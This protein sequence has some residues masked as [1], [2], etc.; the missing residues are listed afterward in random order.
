MLQSVYNI[1]TLQHR[2][3]IGASDVV[4]ALHNSKY[5]QSFLSTRC[6]EV[7]IIIS[8]SLPFSINKHH[9]PK[10]TRILAAR[11]QGKPQTSAEEM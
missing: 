6:R 8:V 1:Y 3:S 5:L 11:D 2:M 9:Y 4:Y 10:G 7:V